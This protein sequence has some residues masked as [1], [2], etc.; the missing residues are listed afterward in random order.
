MKCQ[1]FEKSENFFKRCKLL[2]IKSALYQNLKLS[3]EPHVEVGTVPFQW[4][5]KYR[6]FLNFFYHK[7]KCFIIQNLGLVLTHNFIQLKEAIS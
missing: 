5:L 4:M 6:S 3:L 7:K 1:V 2:F